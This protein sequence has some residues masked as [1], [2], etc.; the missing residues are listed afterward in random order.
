LHQADLHLDNSESARLATGRSPSSVTFPFFT[1]CM[2]FLATCFER[3]VEQAGILKRD[4]RR[5]M[6]RLEMLPETGFV[7]YFKMGHTSRDASQV[8][9][10]CQ[11][12]LSDCHP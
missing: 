8:I 7:G 10:C 12:R 3:V 2:S 6:R 4:G 11:R 5:L 9:G 1:L